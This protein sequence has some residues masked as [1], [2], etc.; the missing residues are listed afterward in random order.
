ML[1]NIL[2]IQIVGLI[3][4]SIFEV[5]EPCSMEFILILFQPSEPHLSCCFEYIQN[6][7]SQKVTTM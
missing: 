6:I 1:A 5:I 3:S 4:S 2:D 7:A